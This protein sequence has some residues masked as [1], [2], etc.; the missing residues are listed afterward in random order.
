MFEMMQQQI[1][2]QLTDKL[3]K[4]SPV[5]YKTKNILSMML[6]QDLYEGIKPQ[7]VLQNQKMMQQTSAQQT[8]RENAMAQPIKPTQK[9]LDSLTMNTQYMTAMQKSTQRVQRG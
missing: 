7:D 6:G 2:S 5:N 3:A 8:A 4:K 1:V 9:G